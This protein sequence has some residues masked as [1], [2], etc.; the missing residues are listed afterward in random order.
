[1]GVYD[2]QRKA[3]LRTDLDR[4]LWAGLDKTAFNLRVKGTGQHLMP[5]PL[6]FGQAYDQPPV[7]SYSAVITN[8]G[9]G[10]PGAK[11]LV[12]LHPD[13]IAASYPASQGDTLATQGLFVDGSFEH[14]M[15]FSDP[16]I[17]VLSDSTYQKI[18]TEKYSG[19]WYPIRPGRNTN[20]WV[21]G[22]ETN[23]RWA[24]STDRYNSIPAPDREGRHSA[25]YTFD[26]PGSSRWLYPTTAASPAWGIQTGTEE[27]QRFECVSHT[28]DISDHYPGG[29]GQVRGPFHNP[30]ANT[31]TYEIHTWTDG[32][33]TLEFNWTGW[34]FEG[35]SGGDGD[36][37]A[38]DPSWG[39][40]VRVLKDETFTQPMQP[41]GWEKHVFEVYWPHW[42]N[43][44]VAP[45][46]AGKI[47]TVP[48]WDVP[49]V[50]YATTRFRV[51]GGTT[52]QVAHFDDA[53]GYLNLQTVPPASLITIGVAEWIRDERGSYVGARLWFR[54]ESEGDAL[55]T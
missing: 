13:F 17:P 32:D 39:N 27:Q 12:R 14:Q 11:S 49:T 30:G 20:G 50:A 38:G 24:V 44:P 1:M 15:I 46:L 55:A 47:G 48:D 18:Y 34:D 26:V 33:A 19:S 16:V 3:T 21:Q 31:Y 2:R 45:I 25:K 10:Y 53:S 23:S 8:A 29:L 28:L 6:Y 7:F 43:A 51:T 36:Y 41:G 40:T 9:V 22:F 37:F 4:Q 42:P 5:D 54:A 35:W 52:G